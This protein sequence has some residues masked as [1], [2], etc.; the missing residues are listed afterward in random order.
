MP[1]DN[2]A[3]NQCGTSRRTKGI[4]LFKLPTSRKADD[5]DT[6]EWRAR[7]L[8][9]LKKYRVEDENFKRQLEANSLHVCEKHFLPDEIEICKLFMLIYRFYSLP[10]NLL[11]VPIP[12]PSV[13]RP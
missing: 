4:G 8:K 12:I 5:V 6:T 9:V 11:L 10:G 3:F 13:F 7:F 1:G 2:C